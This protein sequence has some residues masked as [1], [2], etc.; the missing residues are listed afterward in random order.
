M[1]IAGHQPEYLPYLGLIC[2]A[3]QADVFVFVDHNQYGK[4]QFQNRNRIRTSN[5]SSGWIWL[6]VPVIT[7]GRFN[8]KI[9]DVLIN[10]KLKWREKHFRSICYSYKGTP[11]FENY[12]PLF[13]KIYLQE[14]E[15]LEDLN[16]AILRVIFK[17]LDRDVNIMKT[18]DYNIVGE[19]TDML[20]DMCKK[21]GADGY[22]SGQG[23]KL[24]VDESKFKKAGLSHQYCEFKHPVYK[25]KFKPFVPSM[26]SIDLLFNCGPESKE[27]ILRSDE[28]KN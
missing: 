11:F 2:K 20:L 17:I 12:I 9:K 23:G 16:E 14:W 27:I 7:H 13:E 3:M 8:Q 22:L 21:I 1:I 4:K 24:Y 6:T 5:G 15:K 28:R 26:S 18:S 10:N 19:K 25:Q